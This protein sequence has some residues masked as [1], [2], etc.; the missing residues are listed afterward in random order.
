MGHFETSSRVPARSVDPPTADMQ[1]P[2]LHVSF[3]PQPDS[4]SAANALSSRWFNALILREPI[5]RYLSGCYDPKA[6]KQ[7]LLN[8]VDKS[9]VR[10]MKCI[11][12]QRC[13]SL[14]RFFA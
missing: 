8:K 4:C 12:S 5:G 1:G 11:V 10:F 6:A 7:A 3:V 2:H 13:S 14:S 9:N